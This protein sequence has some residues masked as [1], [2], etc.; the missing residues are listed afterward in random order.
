MNKFNIKFFT[1]AMLLTSLPFLNKV[2]PY[3]NK[4]A[5]NKNVFQPKIEKEAEIPNDVKEF[6]ENS[7]IKYQKEH[8]INVTIPQN[9]VNEIFEDVQNSSET[10]VQDIDVEETDVKQ[11]ETNEVVAE[12]PSKAYTD[13]KYI[14]QLPEFPTGCEC[15]SAVMLLQHKGVNISAADFI[16]NYLP[17]VNNLNEYYNG[18]K[19]QNADKSL[20][21]H[22]YFVG[23][24]RKDSGTACDLSVIKKGVD[25]LLADKNINDFECVDLEGVE[26]DTV[27]DKLASGEPVEIRITINLENPTN[28]ELYGQKYKGW[29]HAVLLTGY[30]MDKEVNFNGKTYKGVVY[31]NDPLEGQKLYP[32]SLV[33]QRYDEMGQLAMTFESKILTNDL[34]AM[35][36]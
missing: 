18:T 24:P 10:V 27:L 2:N 12:R 7:I 32:L 29:R 22:N 5:F 11:E 21:F 3:N 6:I 26:F 8:N 34:T 36:R 33:K 1:A 19:Q 35:Q 16:D 17:K 14:S 25:K 23:D 28:K 31:T 20:V 9:I 30:D 13:V 15:V 4:L